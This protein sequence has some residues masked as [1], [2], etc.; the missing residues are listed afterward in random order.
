MYDKI[1]YKLKKKEKK[2]GGPV[3]ENPPTNAGETPLEPSS[4]K[5]CV[6]MLQL[7]KPMPQAHAQQQKK[8]SNKNPVHPSKE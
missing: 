5:Y 6:C 1:H 7:L 4:Y 2:I 3:V 8:P